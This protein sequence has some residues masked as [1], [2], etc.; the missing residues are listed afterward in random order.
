M[1]DARRLKRVQQESG[2]NQTRVW[3]QQNLAL[4]KTTFQPI[5][6]HADFPHRRFACDHY[7]ARGWC[8]ASISPCEVLS[9]SERPIRQVKPPTFDVLIP[10]DNKTRLSPCRGAMRAID[11]QR[12]NRLK[13]LNVRRHTQA[14]PTSPGSPHPAPLPSPSAPPAARSAAPSSRRRPRHPPPPPARPHSARA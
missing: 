9:I 12:A 2:A 5:R 11:N 8:C 4:A 7:V 14:P 10:Q 6:D 13:R 1:L 3:S